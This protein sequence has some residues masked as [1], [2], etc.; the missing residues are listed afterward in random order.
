[1]SIWRWSEYWNSPPESN[2]IS[3]GE[4][5]TPLLRSR[6]IGP[7]V[8]IN[9]LW[10]KL[11]TGNPSGSYKDRFAAAAI[12]HMIA[13]GQKTCI[14]TSSGN[15]GAALAAYCAAAKIR[16]HISVVEAAP[17]AKLLQMRAYGAE[18]IRV[19][20]FGLN[21]EITSQ[22]FD[23]L[24]EQGGS[25]GHAL[26]ISAYRY[27]PK[28]MAGVESIAFEL[29]EQMVQGINHVFSPAGGGGLTLATARGFSKRG[30]STSVHCVQ[31]E[32]ND[33][34]AGPLR[35]GRDQARAV[36]CD[37]QISGL[38]VASVIDGDQV[39][40]ECRSSGGTGHLVSDEF[41][42]ECQCRLAQEEGIFCEPA[43][44]VALAGAL[45]AV[46]ANEVSADSQI[47]CL[48]TGSGFKDAASIGR[49]ID[50]DRDI[51]LV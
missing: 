39:I 24:L 9:N 33:T 26:Q 23:G 25:P 12:S 31:P 50:Q 51:T 32:G 1:M 7:A 5:N 28:G 47:V 10:F 37:S 16:C 11:E 36:D 13:E 19:P 21:P 34:I 29:A 3:L 41:V 2:Q 48:V 20:G 45:N 8:G 30:M 18:V 4:G 15:T 38:Q 43:G 40:R 49:M 27:S 6:R 17:D 35:S 46:E 42:W 22:T 14:A 44:A